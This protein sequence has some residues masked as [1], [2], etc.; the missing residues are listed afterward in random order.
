MKRHFILRDARADLTKSSRRY[1]DEG[2]LIVDALIA[3][4][5]IQEYQGFELPGKEFDNNKTYKIYRPASE[6]FSQKTL[7]SFGQKPVTNEHPYDSGGWLT[8]DTAT[9][10]LV[11]VSG[12]AATRAGNSIK[13]PLTIYSADMIADIENGKVGLSAGYKCDL[14]MTPGV[15]KSGE[16][17]DG[18]QQN[19][20]GNHIA[21]CDTNAARG[22]SSCRILDKKQ[23]RTVD[24]R[25]PDMTGIDDGAGQSYPDLNDLNQ[26]GQMI[27]ELKKSFAEGIQ[28]IIQ[29]MKSSASEDALDGSDMPDSAE[30]EDVDALPVKMGAADVDAAAEDDTSADEGEVEVP[31]KKPIS[32]KTTDKKRR[33][34]DAAQAPAL[35]QMRREI[36]NLRGQLAVAKKSVINDQHIN[37]IVSARVKL[38]NDAQKVLPDVDLNL[39]DSQAIK[40]A[41]IKQVMPDIVLDSSPAFIDGVYQSCVSVFVKGVNSSDRL[42]GAIMDSYPEANENDLALLD[43]GKVSESARQAM[44]ERNRNMW[45]T[46]QKEGA[47]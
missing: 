6:V 37:R 40:K 25:K 43:S 41:V 29:A 27:L 15:T 34:Q 12:N 5:G 20:N 45:K 44:I 23:T 3:R 30:P 9:K 21:I 11:G 17:Y 7:D 14:L 36:D 2:Y 28:S 1:T 10:K 16:A 22:G 32:G 4:T 13:V 46:S 19:I 8:A 26:V 38:I 39:M 18:I 42:A 31:A 35:A 47:K 24:M 33:F